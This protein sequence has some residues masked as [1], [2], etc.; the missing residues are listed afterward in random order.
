V[1]HALRGQTNDV[2]WSHLNGRSYHLI[3]VCGFGFFCVLKFTFDANAQELSHSKVMDLTVHLYNEM[4]TYWRI[5]WNFTATLFALTN[6]NNSV[7]MWA[8]QGLDQWRKIIT[9]SE[10]YEEGEKEKEY[11][12]PPLN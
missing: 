10:T 2:S 8:Y 5:S 12:E 7:Q 1:H 9:A 6:H 11:P 3:G 4:K